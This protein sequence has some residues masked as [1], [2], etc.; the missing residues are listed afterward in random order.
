MRFCHWG[1]I[2]TKSLHSPQF[3]HV[4]EDHPCPRVTTALWMAAMK[5]T[6]TARG[7]EAVGQR[8]PRTMWVGVEVAAHTVGH[9]CPGY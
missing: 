9:C 3:S 5:K 2:P 6:G 4:R 1:A 7:G 8:S